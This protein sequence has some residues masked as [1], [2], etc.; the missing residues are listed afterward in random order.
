MVAVH[1]EINASVDAVWAVLADGWIYPSWVV[2]ASR[3]RAVDPNWPA[4]GAQL[5]HSI[6]SWPVMLD[7]TTSV[8]SCTP[9]SEL[10]LRGRGW[11]MGEV[12]IELVLEPLAGGGC[13]LLMKEDVVAGP[14]KLLPPPVRAALIGPRNVETLK[15]LAYIAEGGSR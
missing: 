12:E 9:R 1:R 11:P 3:M 2:G 7:D 4:V 10:V 15:R 8:V 14:T 13:G 6:G 5:H